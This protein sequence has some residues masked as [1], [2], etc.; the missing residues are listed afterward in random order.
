MASLRRNGG[1]CK[2]RNSAKYTR[3]S[4]SSSSPEGQESSKTKKED[5]VISVKE[6]SRK[7]PLT[8]NNTSLPRNGTYQGRR[9]S[10][11]LQENSSSGPGETNKLKMEDEVM[12]TKENG[13]K[14]PLTKSKSA[15]SRNG[16]N[17]G[18]RGALSLQEN[19]DTVFREI[20][21]CCD[22]DSSVYL[23][24][25]SVV[26]PSG[27]KSHYQSR[28][29]LKVLEKNTVSARSPIFQCHNGRLPSSK[30]KSSYSIE[31]STIVTN[32]A[33]KIPF[34]NSSQLRMD[35]SESVV[36]KTK[37][38]R[39]GQLN[40]EKYSSNPSSLSDSSV[41]SDD[42]EF[43]L[44]SSISSGMCE[45]ELQDLNLL[46]DEFSL[47]K[48]VGAPLVTR[49][50]SQTVADGEFQAFDGSR[51][52]PIQE[53]SL[54][55]NSSIA[56]ACAS[57]AD[58]EAETSSED[59]DLFEK[60]QALEMSGDAC[61]EILQ[62]Q[63]GNVDSMLALEFSFAQFCDP[64]A[65]DVMSTSEEWASD[66]KF[67]LEGSTSGDSCL[68]C[69]S[70][71]SLPTQ[72]N[73]S[74][75]L[76]EMQYLFHHQE[77]DG[78]TS[79]EFEQCIHGEISSRPSSM[80]FEDEANKIAD[81]LVA[82]AT[83]SSENSN[84]ASVDEESISIF[85]LEHSMMQTDELNV[86]R[87]EELLFLPVTLNSHLY[88]ENNLESSLGNMG[89]G[90]G[91]PKIEK[92]TSYKDKLYD[93]KKEYSTMPRRNARSIEDFV[94]D[95]ISAESKYREQVLFSTTGSNV[96]SN[97]CMKSVNDRLKLTSETFFN[98]PELQTRCFKTSEDS[99][100]VLVG[101]KEFDGQ[102]GLQGPTFEVTSSLCESDARENFSNADC[103]SV[104]HV[105]A[106]K[107]SVHE[108]AEMIGESI[109]SK[110][111]S[112]SLNKECGLDSFTSSEATETNVSYNA[113]LIPSKPAVLIFGGDQVVDPKDS[114][115]QKYGKQKHNNREYSGSDEKIH[116]CVNFNSRFNGN[117]SFVN[118]KQKSILK[119]ICQTSSMEN[120]KS[121]SD[122]NSQR[123]K[124]YLLE[125][126]NGV[127][128]HK[129][130]VARES[131]LT[132]GN[133]GNHMPR[134]N[135][136]NCPKSLN[137]FSV[138]PSNWLVKIGCCL[139]PYKNDFSA[140]YL[141][142]ELHQKQAFT[143]DIFSCSMPSIKP[144]YL[145]KD[146]HF[147]VETCTSFRYYSGF[148]H[149][150]CT[151]KFDIIPIQVRECGGW[152]HDLEKYIGQ[153]QHLKKIGCESVPRNLIS[154]KTEN[155]EMF[156]GHN[157]RIF[158]GVNFH[159]SSCFLVYVNAYG[160]D[161][162]YSDQSLHE[163]FIDSSYKEAVEYLRK[164]KL[165]K[166]PLQFI[167]DRNKMKLCHAEHVQN[168]NDATK[169]DFFELGD[170]PSY[171]IISCT[172]CDDGYIP[173]LLGPL[174][175]H[176][177]LSSSDQIEIQDCQ[178]NCL[179]IWESDST[180]EVDFIN[181]TSCNDV[182]ILDNNL[183][184]IMQYSENSAGSLIEPSSCECFGLHMS[185]GCE[186]FQGMQMKPKYKATIDSPN[187]G[188]DDWDTVAGVN[189]G[190]MDTTTCSSEKGRTKETISS[191]LFD[192][193]KC[194]NI[195]SQDN[196]IDI[197]HERM[198]GI[199][200]EEIKI[201]TH[202]HHND[203]PNFA[204]RPVNVPCLAGSED[205]LLSSHCLLES[206]KRK[207][208]FENNSQYIKGLSEMR[209]DGMEKKVQM[210]ESELLEVKKQNHKMQSLLKCIFRR[211]DIMQQCLQDRKR[212]WHKRHLICKFAIRLR[213]KRKK[214]QTEAL[215]FQRTSCKPYLS[216]IW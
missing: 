131:G 56:G 163:H 92:Q 30:L 165:G 91:Q 36:D 16:T 189:Y 46:P 210:L 128:D 138:S 146:I 97:A 167:Y 171:I 168:V 173:E 212:R 88:E 132:I 15:L 96:N 52:T 17:H 69:S 154:I 149:N 208:P 68:T 60:L 22:K 71:E 19:S 12:N 33:S 72:N 152:T 61:T 207:E 104:L 153:F 44:I 3:D 115:L 181:T 95:A 118:L 26:Q 199:E 205:V 144:A 73:L 179:Q 8:R 41:R 48:W 215:D 84:S 140:L 53:A 198:G 177:D 151:G 120:G 110:N 85:A 155:K 14:R 25:T 196:S 135:Q 7:C 101:M 29:L 137:C 93:L 37:K 169:T 10:L 82:S 192:G 59:I 176:E 23:L 156:E 204:P 50:K 111:L 11:S 136:H 66:D 79:C 70:F 114:W 89:S 87:N 99:I 31:N 103:S 197:L 86:F 164:C 186:E 141:M 123:Q 187:H 40:E 6:T 74:P 147:A 38:Q 100:E 170:D 190:K 83:Q 98:F 54:V 20:N 81:Q 134:E 1:S 39:V 213:R 126:E 211:T 178:L 160:K 162:Y 185:H 109:C 5:E 42:L 43:D 214:H 121:E 65:K 67:T 133:S 35:T 206:G 195:S 78:M 24:D 150:S 194:N 76:G 13:R 125:Q 172:Q 47:E 183:R 55:F 106:N 130:R 145:E 51:Y 122:K 2:I 45:Q 117:L 90:A 49:E 203:S 175:L 148:E 180:K 143:S 108:K 57:V 94:H 18:Y 157:I 201:V 119:D 9:Q 75:C 80:F 27:T 182:E 193:L 105:L 113:P 202:I 62:I 107:E 34:L 159:V 64:W 124:A 161:D 28:G 63:D 158:L 32:K 4:W 112:G 216:K 127:E 209:E 77:C 184:G 142:T 139:A 166:Y 21:S 200:V 191:G 174:E 116:S 129:R 188:H 102:E 58:E